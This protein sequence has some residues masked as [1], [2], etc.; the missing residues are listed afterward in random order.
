M[1]QKSEVEKDIRA[2]RADVVVCLSSDLRGDLWSIWR[3][4]AV[5]GVTLD[6]LR[7]VKKTMEEDGSRHDLWIETEI[8]E[9]R[10]LVQ[11]TNCLKL[12]HDLP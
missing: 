5:A 4:R 6:W 1:C 2:M 10:E 7:V 12:L 9:N 8:A 11:S 3:L